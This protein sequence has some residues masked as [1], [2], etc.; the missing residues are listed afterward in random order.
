MKETAE[1]IGLMLTES[2]F[3]VFEKMLFTFLNPRKS[4]PRYLIWKQRSITTAEP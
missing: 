1:R 3:E 4:R 2:I